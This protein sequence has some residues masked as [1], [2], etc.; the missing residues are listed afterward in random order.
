MNGGILPAFIIKN[1]YKLMLLEDTRKWKHAE[2]STC[3]IF[4]FFCKKKLV[5]E[6]FS[7]FCASS[8][9]DLSSVGSFH[10]LTEA[11][12]LFSLTL[13]GLV[14][15]KHS[16]APPFLNSSAHFY[17]LKACVKHAYF[18]IVINII[19]YLIPFCQ[20]PFYFLQFLNKSHGLRRMVSRPAFWRKLGK[21][22]CMG[23]R[24][25]AGF[26]TLV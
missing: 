7:S 19:Y 12:L 9:Q 14:C 17:S 20:V 8:L 16:R 2:C 26:S 5:C 3:V 21:D 6:S 4:T 22:F 18:H 15:S 1:E 24:P 11:V 23:F 10:A 25:I 13:L